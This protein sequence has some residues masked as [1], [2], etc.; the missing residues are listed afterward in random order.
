MA[1]RLGQ[2]ILPQKE[3][4]VGEE[5]GPVSSENVLH[6]IDMCYVESNETQIVKD[7]F[8]QGVLDNGSDDGI[9]F[10]NE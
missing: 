7:N 6:I 2:K 9:V 10:L 3:R 4:Y 8:L 1:Y 5:G